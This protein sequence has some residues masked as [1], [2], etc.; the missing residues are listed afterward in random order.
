MG[1]VERSSDRRKFR[2][3]M[4]GELV[5]RILE[6][7]WKFRKKTARELVKRILEKL[8]KIPEKDK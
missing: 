6:K 3:K 1:S 2:R 7:P 4:A 5:R 8:W